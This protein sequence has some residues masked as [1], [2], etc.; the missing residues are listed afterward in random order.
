MIETFGQKAN[1]KIQFRRVVNRRVTL[2]RTTTRAF[3]WRPTSW[4]LVSSS[5]WPGKKTTRQLVAA[6]DG[7]V[8]LVDTEWTTTGRSMQVRVVKVVG[9]GFPRLTT[10]DNQSFYWVGADHQLHQR[11]FSWDRLKFVGK[12]R[13]LPVSIN[14]AT[15]MTSH[16][17]DFGSRVYYTDKSGAL[18]AVLVDGARS[19]DIVLRSSGFATTTGLRSGF[20]MSPNYVHVRPYVGLLS[21]DRTTGIGRFQRVI[22]PGAVTGGTLTKSVRVRPSGWTWRRLG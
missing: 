7:K 16:T 22:R 3:K 6:T 4:G 12:Q 10:F 19:T 1:G 9:R 11:A 14:G 21:V 13:T 18:H 15:A 2:T 17:T 8:R 20:C 5:G